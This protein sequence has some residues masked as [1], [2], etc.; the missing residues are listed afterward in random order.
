VGN[1]K[2]RKTRI[3]QLEQ[4]EGIVVGEEKLK[5]YITNFYKKNLVPLRKTIL[6]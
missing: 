5:S 3:F 4:E 1:E 2:Q 6:A